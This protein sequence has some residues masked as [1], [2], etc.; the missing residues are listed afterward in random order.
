M[1]STIRLVSTIELLVCQRLTPL[2]SIARAGQEV[3]QLLH[4]GIPTGTWDLYGPTGDS[5]YHRRL[6]GH[7]YQTEGE[8]RAAAQALWG[9]ARA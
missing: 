6:A 3:G 7:A 5:R 2:V 9:E 1:I 4:R 8:A